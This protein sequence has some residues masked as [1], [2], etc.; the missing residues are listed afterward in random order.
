MDPIIVLSVVGLLVSLYALQVELRRKH[1]RRY[2]PFC[3]FSKNMSCSKALLSEEGRLFG[4][5]NAL[6]GILGYI[7]II[8]ASY[9]GLT[10]VV[11]AFALSAT[12]LSVY[13]AY[14]LYKKK[15]FCIVCIAAY[16]INAFI[17]ILA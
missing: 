17:L 1:N 15:N 7:A 4:I 6:L 11:F 16:S 5:P 12:L 3:D 8:L 13:L 2:K 14:I 10:Q 9:A